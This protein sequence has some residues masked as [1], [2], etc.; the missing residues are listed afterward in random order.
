MCKRKT[1]LTGVLYRLLVMLTV[2]VFAASTLYI[3]FVLELSHLMLCSLILAEIVTVCRLIRREDHVVNGVP[4]VSIWEVALAIYRTYLCRIAGYLYHCCYDTVDVPANG[5]TTRNAVWTAVVF[6]AAF[7]LLASHRPDVLTNPQPYVEDGKIFIAGAYNDGLRCLFHPYA[8]YLHTFQRIVSLIAV[9]ISILHAP[10]IM[11]TVALAV[12]AGTCAFIATS[13]RLAGQFPSKASRFVAAALVV[14]FP[15]SPELL[16]MLTDVQWTFPIL[17]LAI[18]CAKPPASSVRSALDYI[19]IVILSLTG[20]FSIMLAP[21]ALLRARSSMHH[22]ILAL[23]V[24]LGAVVQF[25]VVHM[26]QRNGKPCGL[27]YSLFLAGGRVWRTPD[28]GSQGYSL[29]A[30]SPMCWAYRS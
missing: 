1:A 8:G 27:A 20:P 2:F 5:Q 22:T 10:L 9:N 7:I 16:G 30:H 28:P 14:A 13:G 11:N 12:Q 26:T 4:D 25:A 29:Y 24:S 21:I 19:G 18:I 23:L 17:S 3:W 6:S 15:Y